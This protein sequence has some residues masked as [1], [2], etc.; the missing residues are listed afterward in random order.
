MSGDSRQTQSEPGP[1]EDAARPGD[2]V[3]DL[4]FRGL[5]WS[6]LRLPYA[7]RIRTFGW[8][9]ERL[10][11]ASRFGRRIEENLDLV[12]PEMDKAARRTLAR[13][14]ANNSGRLLIENYSG[15]ELAARMNHVE[16]TGPG[17]AALAEAKEAGTPVLLLTGHFGNYE[18]AR[19]SLV[20]RGY[21]VGGLYRPMR[22]PYFNAHYRA[23]MERMG[24]P[25]FPQGRAG[26]K[27][28]IAFLRSG[29][30]AMLLNDLYVGSGLELPFLGHPAMTSTSAAEIAERVGARAIPVW[31]IRQPDGLSFTVEVDA[32]LPEGDPVETTRAYNAACEARIRAHPDQWY[33]IHRRWK[34]KW[35]RGA[36]DR[37]GLHPAQLPS[38]KSRL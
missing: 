15:P 9:T 26:T 33:W 12:Y 34:V 20:A 8:V 17:V 28:L 25:V 21:R 7:P 23:T 2:R 14:S 31:G 37:P 16:P 10:A 38:R 18:A 30:F 4:A 24:P 22:N 3:V 5:L 11:M 19:A 36:G 13:R 6:V 35:Q 32:P 27:G 29:G 1:P